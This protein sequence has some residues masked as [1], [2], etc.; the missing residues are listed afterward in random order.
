MAAIT[1]L[2]NQYIAVVKGWLDER[3]SWL[4]RLLG[5]NKPGCFLKETLQLF[6]LFLLFIF[7]RSNQNAKVSICLN[8]FFFRKISSAYKAI[9]V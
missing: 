7:N 5:F 3:S 2:F 9:K 4:K 8:P 6:I 1:L